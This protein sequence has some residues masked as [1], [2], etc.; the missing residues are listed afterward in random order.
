MR[1]RTCTRP[2]P[3]PCPPALSSRRVGGLKYVG[4]SRHLRRMPCSPARRHRR[5]CHATTASGTVNVWKTPREARRGGRRREQMPECSVTRETC[6]R[7]SPGLAPLASATRFEK[8]R[9]HCKGYVVDRGRC[10]SPRESRLLGCAAEVSL[11]TDLR[12]ACHGK[13]KGW[14][15]YLNRSSCFANKTCPAAGYSRVA[16]FSRACG[17]RVTPPPPGTVPM[18][19]ATTIACR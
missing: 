6:T 3:T 2:L 8:Y 13:L 9:L 12:V 11:L 15:D 14:L 7:R 4:K 19:T 10:S 17:N 16:T 18:S 1:H 5:T